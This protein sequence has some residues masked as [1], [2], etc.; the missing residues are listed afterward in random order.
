MDEAINQAGAA[1]ITNIVGSEPG[2]WSVILFSDG[3]AKVAISNLIEEYEFAA[4]ESESGKAKLLDASTAD[5]VRSAIRQTS[6]EDVCIMRGLENWSPEQIEALDLSR[7]VFIDR[8]R[9]AIV[10]TA[11]GAALFKESAPNLW[12]WIGSRCFSFDASAGIMDKEVR[13]DSLRKHFK[14][15]DAEVLRMARSG[16]LPDEPVFTEWLVLLGEDELLG[17]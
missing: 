16:E 6:P 15:S 11:A 1:A 14:L 9:V 8:A 7:N 13:L 10:T 5:E 3:R 4:S 12:S 17:Q 2:V